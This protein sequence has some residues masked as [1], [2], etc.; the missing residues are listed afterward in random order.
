VL[1]I[2]DAKYVVVAESITKSTAVTVTED[3][4]EQERMMKGTIFA[5]EAKSEAKLAAIMPDA[6]DHVPMIEG[7]LNAVE[8]KSEAGKEHAEVQ[9]PTIQDLI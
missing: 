7:S 2:K 5:V 4:A 8:T 3:A 1:L 9:D 6:A